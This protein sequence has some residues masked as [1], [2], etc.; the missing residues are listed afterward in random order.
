M[1]VERGNGPENDMLRYYDCPNCGKL[2]HYRKDDIIIEEC[3]NCGKS[4][5]QILGLNFRLTGDGW[6]SSDAGKL[7]NGGA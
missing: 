2:E 4:I 1:G 7:N 5:R 6:Y 3:P